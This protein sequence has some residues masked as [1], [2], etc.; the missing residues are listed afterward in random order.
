MFAATRFRLGGIAFLIL[1]SACAA[2]P[3][4]A[5][6]PSSWVP[7]AIQPAP[8]PPGAHFGEALANAGDLDGD[9]QDDLVVGAPDYTDIDLGSGLSGTRVCVTLQRSADLGG[10]GSLP[11][12]VACRRLRPPSGRRS[13]S[14]RTS[15]SCTY[16]RG[17]AA[18]SDAPDGNAEVLVSA[19]GTDTSSGTGVDQGAVYV[20]DGGSGLMLKRC[21]SSER[22]ATGARPDSASRSRRCRDSLRAT[23]GAGSRL[24][25][26][27]RWLGGRIR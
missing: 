1:A 16:R 12:G 8:S 3:A 14:S 25:P 22:P 2:A 5:A 24:V 17:V 4:Q 26:V 10:E 27:R 6:L 19:P 11:A 9:G 18:S 20:L 13:Q 21:S 23:R 15:G 7:G